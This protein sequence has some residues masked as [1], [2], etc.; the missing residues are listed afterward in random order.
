MHQTLLH[1]K[2]KLTINLC[3]GGCEMSTCAWKQGKTDD[4]FPKCFSRIA[5][6]LWVGTALYHDSTQSTL[7]YSTAYM[8]ILRGRADLI[9]YK[10]GEG[11]RNATRSNL[12]WTQDL[13]F[14]QMSCD[15]I[16]TYQTSQ[17][18]SYSR[19]EADRLILRIS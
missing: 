12:S 1:K 4:N 18:G 17:M 7:R 8:N 9:S 16:H 6:C 2:D 5:H 15:S 3:S 10:E 11:K 14:S 13:D 19:H